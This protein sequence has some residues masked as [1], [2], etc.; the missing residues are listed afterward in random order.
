MRAVRKKKAYEDIVKQLMA[1]IQKG[2][3]KRGDQ[4]PNERD[5]AEI[6]KVSRATVREAILSLEAIKVVDRRQGDG[7]YV[8]AS[9]EEMMIRPLAAALFHERDDIIDIFSIRKIIEPELAS[10]ASRNRTSEELDELEAILA[11]QE[12]QVREGKM[13]V[14]TD[15]DFHQFLA[16]MAKNTVL[17]RLTFA[18]FDLMS[19]TREHYL[20][21]AA[22]QQKS[23]AGHRAV[24]EAIRSGDAQAERRAMRK[25][26]ESVE[27]VVFES[28]KGG[29]K[30][31]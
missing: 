30:D 23:L 14:Q 10:M 7:T 12:T 13:P 4:L 18:L 24:L 25:H 28:R 17:E 1:Q 22:R 3:L 19:K 8:I 9:R 20:Q 29:G 5:L 15:S 31:A 11:A 6:F 2:K 16:R 26:L 21:T 27:D